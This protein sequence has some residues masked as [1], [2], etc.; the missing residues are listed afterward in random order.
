MVY[1]NKHFIKHVPV[2][3][4]AKLLAERLVDADKKNSSDYTGFESQFTNMTFDIELILYAFMLENIPQSKWILD[5]IESLLTGDNWCKFKRLVAVLPSGR[6]SGEMNTSLGNGFMNLMLFL[7]QNF[8]LKNTNVDCFVEGDDLIGVYR[9]QPLA[10]EFYA[11]LG[12]KIKLE[13]HQHV[14]HA[15]FC[16]LIYDPEE[17]VSIADPHKVLLNVGWTSSRYINAK[18]DT[19]NGLL[20]AKGYS[21]LYQYPGVPIIQSLALY[22]LRVTQGVKTRLPSEW[23]HWQRKQ[24]SYH[25]VAK[26]VGMRTRM[27]MEEIFKYTVQEQ[28]IL[29]EYF[30]TKMDISPIDHF[31]ILGH[32]TEEQKH[33]C[34]TYVM[35]YT[36]HGKYPIIRV[37]SITTRE[38]ER[39][40]DLMLQNSGT[41][42][43]TNDRKINSDYYM[44]YQ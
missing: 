15:S 42:K 10:S 19:L 17:L 8:K 37:P 31:V 28:E 32:A 13:H 20:R 25:G 14:S 3:D 22:L 35:D 24:F 33:Y 2:A 44:P 26:P 21:L 36:V 7:F 29:E 1:A 4:R 30:D 23:T 39:L 18:Q 9:G 27:L 41:V 12:F 34:E 38:S 40:V 16:G 5:L 43:L 11:K 6:M